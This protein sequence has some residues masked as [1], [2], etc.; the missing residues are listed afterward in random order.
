V[1]GS[2]RHAAKGSAPEF[3]AALQLVDNA[4]VGN[5]VRMK[6]NSPLI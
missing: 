3:D 2:K 5:L 6:T 4:A 1:T